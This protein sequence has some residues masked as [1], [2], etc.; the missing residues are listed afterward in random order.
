MINSKLYESEIENY[1]S[2]LVPNS[3]ITQINQLIMQNK[4]SNKKYPNGF[5]ALICS[6]M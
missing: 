4:F 6:T 2:A 5:I 1:I 3:D